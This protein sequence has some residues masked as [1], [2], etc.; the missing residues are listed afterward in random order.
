VLEGVVKDIKDI[1][2]IT[3]IE[4]IKSESLDFRV[5]VQTV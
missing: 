2:D 5:I 1:K 3:D 4:D